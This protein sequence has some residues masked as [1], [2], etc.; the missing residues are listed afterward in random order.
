MRSPD[1]LLSKISDELSARIT[2]AVNS[3]RS[4]SPNLKVLPGFPFTVIRAEKGHVVANDT[5]EERAAPV[6]YELG[7]DANG[8]YIDF[9]LG[10]P[11]TVNRGYPIRLEYRKTGRQ[12]F[13]LKV[14][15]EVESS[16]VCLDPG[17]P[18]SWVCVDEDITTTSVEV[19]RRTTIPEQENPT[20]ESPCGGD[21]VE[22]TGWGSFYGSPS[23]KYTVYLPLLCLDFGK[24]A[25]LSFAGD[26]LAEIISKNP[27]Y[28]YLRDTA[29][30]GGDS[31]RLWWSGGLEYSAVNSIQGGDPGALSVA[32]IV[33]QPLDPEDSEYVLSSL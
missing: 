32:G 15:A 23:G 7:S 2:A 13:F 5:T 16:C 11:T 33:A 22:G 14:V 4:A 30:Q 20:T 10:N 28:P 27:M 29:L 9:Y 25:P 1:E 26:K 17:P 6:I 12:F 24:R 19:V 3:S 8:N 31:S 18:A 21:E